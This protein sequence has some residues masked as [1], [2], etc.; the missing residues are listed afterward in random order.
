MQGIAN[1]ESGDI[2]FQTGATGLA[3]RMQIK[4]S[5]GRIGIGTAAPNAPLHVVG[6]NSGNVGAFAFYAAAGCN[7]STGNCGG[8]INDYSIIASNRIAATEFNAYSDARIKNVTSLT[9]PDEDLATIN[10]LQV[11]NFTYKDIATNGADEKKGFIAQQ[12][13]TVFPQ[14]VS[15][16][17]DF[18][19][20]IY[21]VAEVVEQDNLTLILR[22]PQMHDLV[23]TD[24]IRII[25]Q[26][27]QMEKPVRSI[28]PDGSIVLEHV[29]EPVTQAFIFG[30]KVSDFRTVD[31][32]RIYTA[33][34]GAI[35]ALSK[36]VVVLENVNSD[37]SKDNLLLRAE[38]E[39]LKQEFAQMSEE[40]QR[41][42]SSI[43]TE[44]AN[45]SLLEERLNR[46][47]KYVYSQTDIPTHAANSR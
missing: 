39:R 44:Q 4:G 7:V 3:T 43:A 9:Q 12:V 31:Y 17:Q 40:K 47:E 16:N 20:N 24:T 11:T 15:K 2:I 33:G 30:K 18:I 36:K 32:D 1:T 42:E 29:S 25:T 22:L 34:I 21:Q 10:R 26:N 8:A 28:L 23:A 5:N 14:A 19:P 38:M 27:G 35:Q 45:R 37:L 41:L 13:E 6:N 46:L